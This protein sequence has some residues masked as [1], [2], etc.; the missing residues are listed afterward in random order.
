MCGI[1]ERPVHLLG[2]AQPRNHLGRRAVAGGVSV[3]ETSQLALALRCV[4]DDRV[5]CSREQQWAGD[6]L[7]QRHHCGTERELEIGTSQAAR[8]VYLEGGLRAERP[9]YTMSPTPHASPTAALQRRR[10]QCAA[11]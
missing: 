10:F 9:L 6:A 8:T 2:A 1:G 3:G 4:L 7:A 11:R 5:E